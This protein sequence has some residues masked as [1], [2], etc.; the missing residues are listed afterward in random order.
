MASAENS[1]SDT[2]PPSTYVLPRDQI[3]STRLNAQHYALIQRKGWLLHPKVEEAISAIDTPQICE[4]ACGTGVW[5][6]EV[7]EKFPRTFV[8]GLDISAAPFPPEWTWPTN[9]TLG[10]LD[11]L[12]DVPPEYLGKFDV[13]HCRLLLGAGPK[14][15]SRVFVDAFAKLL[16]PGGWLQWEETSYPSMSVINPKNRSNG[17]SAG[18]FEL[19]PH[20]FDSFNEA[21]NMSY[22]TGWFHNFCDWMTRNSNFTDIEQLNVPLLPRIAQIG[23]DTSI[24]AWLS[25]ANRLIQNPKLDDAL[26]EG[27]KRE[28]AQFQTLN[29]EGKL[30]TLDIIVGI[31]KAPGSPSA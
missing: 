8:T 25:A 27:I 3:E 21:I 12:G 19:T 6:L 13:L 29:E 15:N 24:T 1:T 26:K 2:T 4:V 18:D 22:K 11:L 28:I 17:Q 5:T 14:V 10:T 20:R 16:K 31:A 9:S 7:A 23:N 30:I